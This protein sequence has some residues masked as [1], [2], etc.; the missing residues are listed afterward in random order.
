MKDLRT[1]KEEIIL[2]LGSFAE[3]VKITLYEDK[4][5]IVDCFDCSRFIK[6]GNLIAENKSL[7]C[8]GDGMYNCYYVEYK[9]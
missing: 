8:V 9:D 4:F 3:N 5:Y 1:L 7:K 6:C 2:A